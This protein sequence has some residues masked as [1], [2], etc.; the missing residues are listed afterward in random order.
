M[1]TSS[2][3]NLHERWG[4]YS[5]QSHRLQDPTFRT[6]VLAFART[7]FARA[8]AN[9]ERLIE[10]LGREG[11]RFA[12]PELVRIAPEAG[13]EDWIVEMEQRSVYL[14]ISL[15]A[16][17]LEVGSVNLMGSHPSWPKTGYAFDDETNDVT[18]ADPLVVE[19]S[20]SYVQYLHEEWLAAVEELG[21]AEIGPFT[22][23]FAPDYIHK[24]N[25]SGG[26][27]YA[28]QAVVPA[29]DALVLNE[30]GCVSFMRHIRE[31]V[32]W[33]GFPGFA[34]QGEPAV[35]FVSRLRGGLEVI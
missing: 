24:S 25:V 22:I 18:Y 7:Q 1:T 8:A 4:V 10:V 20:Q 29:V 14:P 27:A 5:G 9:I 16:W 35:G 31:A 11:Y 21:A 17:M 19:A 34:Y 2:V 6:E 32:W 26:A 13:T 15:Q 3:S 12:E 28:V 30:R 33:A 23:H